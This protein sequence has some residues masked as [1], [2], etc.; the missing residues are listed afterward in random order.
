ML[1]AKQILDRGIVFLTDEAKDKYQVELKPAQ[2]GI[3]LHMVSCSKIKRDSFGIIYDDTA[4]DEN[5]K[6]LKT[7]IA[8]T[9]ICKPVKEPLLA[10]PEKDAQ[11]WILDEGEYEIGFAEGCNFDARSVGKIV[12]RSSVRRNGCEINSPLWDPGFHT[13]E[14][15]TFLSVKNKIKIYVG[16]RVAQMIVFETKEEAEKYD[17]QY[18]N[19]GVLNGKH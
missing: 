13:N 11:Y 12:H 15:G 18:Q 10:I 14:M 2:A 5:G 16:A 6:P 9:E 1:T 19:T 3:D 8:E 4:K 17:G 7:K